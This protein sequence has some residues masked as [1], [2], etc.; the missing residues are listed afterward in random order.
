MTT[1]IRSAGFTMSSALLASAAVAQLSSLTISGRLDVSLGHQRRANGLNMSFVTSE[2]FLYQ[3]S[4]P[5]RPRRGM[6][7]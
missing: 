6:S 3:F 4:G 2:H 5:G 1:V 7:A